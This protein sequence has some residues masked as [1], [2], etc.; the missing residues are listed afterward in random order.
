MDVVVRWLA[1][2][3]P[4]ITHPI[5]LVA[6]SLF[7]VTFL[8]NKL[9]LASGLLSQ[10][11]KK[12]S[13]VL[14]NKI[15]NAAA[16]ALLMIIAL[17]FGAYIYSM[18]LQVSL[19]SKD[20]RLAKGPLA[21]LAR[22]ATEIKAAPLS[23]SIADQLRL[24]VN[25]IYK[26]GQILEPGVA[27]AEIER[28]HKLYALNVVTPALLAISPENL[29]YLLDVPFE[30]MPSTGVTA[31]SV[32]APENL[33]KWIIGDNEAAMAQLEY[34]NILEQR[35]SFPFKD[36]VYF[37]GGIHPDAWDGDYPGSLVRDAAF[38][39]PIRRAL[40]EGRYTEA[41]RSADRFVAEYGPRRHRHVDD[42]YVLKVM[43]YEGAGKPEDALTTIHQALLLKRGDM[44]GWL[45]RERMR[46][47]EAYGTV[48]LVARF[49]DDPDYRQFRPV[50]SYTRAHHL[51]A[52]RRYDEALKTFSSLLSAES[53]ICKRSQGDAAWESR[54]DHVGRRS[55]STDLS[56][57]Q[58]SDDGE[59]DTDADDTPQCLPREVLTNAI[60]TARLLAKLSVDSS[61]PGR[62]QYALAVFNDGLFHYNEILGRY[63]SSWTRAPES[64]YA[65]HNNYYVAASVFEGIAR[66]AGSS[67][68]LKQKALYK[69]GRCYAHLSDSSAFFLD[70]IDGM[71]RRDF[72]VAAAAKFEEAARVWPSG[73]LADDALTESAWHRRTLLG[74]PLGS[75]R[76]LNEVVS[77]YAGRNAEDEAT[78]GIAIS[79]SALQK[80]AEAIGAWKR[81]ETIASSDRVKSA[82][83]G[84]RP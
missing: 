47:L 78:L 53:A 67:L 50:L 35:D 39:I 65:S 37:M 5:T 19:R 9:V 63:R 3:V 71:N 38:Y 28:L 36:L 11:N 69:E 31:R 18:R 51:L 77:K 56:S 26:V 17:A 64:Y 42:A 24:V 14:L 15:L 52:M 25:P 84:H 74:D 75:Y 16:V 73:P 44:L 58:Q 10:V 22:A 13:F 60:K 43:A 49:E 61:P 81:L 32:Y 41:A 80:D 68:E 59:E 70:E 33:D 12:D 79:A 55:E 4:R 1:A 2:L 62:F 30:Y 34:I 45:R 48:D 8:L 6:F 76:L 46:I 21:D 66:D 7:V 83:A 82:L 27:I 20:L 72:A 29:S 23:L 54:P 57:N 40:F